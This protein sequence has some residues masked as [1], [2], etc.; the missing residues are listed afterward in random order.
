MRELVVGHVGSA[1]SSEIGPDQQAFDPPPKH[2][3]SLDAYGVP[4]ACRFEFRVEVRSRKARVPAKEE[5][6]RTPGSVPIKSPIRSHD[7][8]EYAR[9]SDEIGGDHTKCC[10]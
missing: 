6:C 9:L 3:L 10:E 2:G 8:L 1:I 4:N 7:E 5:Y